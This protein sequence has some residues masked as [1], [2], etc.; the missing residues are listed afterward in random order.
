MRRWPGTFYRGLGTPA[1]ACL[2]KFLSIGRRWSSAVHPQ[3]PLE[4]SSFAFLPD[5][6]L[7]TRAPHTGP[8]CII[9]RRIK[10]HILSHCAHV[11]RRETHGGGQCPA[12]TD[13]RGADS[14]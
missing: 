6:K 12:V 7:S 14:G 10:I 9:M 8:T 3:Q 5:C 2:Q 4:S 1:E 11:G 13:R